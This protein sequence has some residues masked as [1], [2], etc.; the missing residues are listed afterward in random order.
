[1]GLSQVSSSLVSDSSNAFKEFPTVGLSVTCSADK[2]ITDSAAGATALA[3][4]HKT[5]NKWISVAPDGTILK[6]VFEYAKDKGKAA[7]VV[8][9][10]TVSNATPACFLGHGTDRKKEREL[11]AQYPDDNWDVI[12]GGGLKYFKPFNDT[13]NKKIFTEKI[14]TLHNSGYLVFTSAD[15][16]LRLKPKSKF[17]A[18][19][20]EDGL[21]GA[22]SRDYTLTDLANAALR[23]VTRN[24]K[25][26]VLMIEGSQIDWALHDNQSREFEAEMKD[27]NRAIHTALNFARKDGNTLVLVTA[28]HETGGLAVAGGKTDSTALSYAYTTKGHTASA[29]GVFA[30]GPGAEKFGGI[31]HIS[32]IGEK[33][34]KLLTDK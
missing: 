9:T 18:L 29:V 33:L 8:V 10:S 21:P 23:A 28:D 12:I 11:A 1:M 13:V 5:N 19:L 4:G 25:G 15:S 14:S 32:G 2:L 20:A 24:K 26:F 22:L 7:G 30:F 27:F 16:L 17:Y 3:T 6:T 31:Q 34:I